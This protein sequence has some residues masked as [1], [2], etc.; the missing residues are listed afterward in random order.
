[1]NQRDGVEIYVSENFQFTLS[2]ALE[3]T[4]RSFKHV[5][6]SQNINVNVVNACIVPEQ[7]EAH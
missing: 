4:E 7:C 6:V 2:L 3:P 1:M 5:D